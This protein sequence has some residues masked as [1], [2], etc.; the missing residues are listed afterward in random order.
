MMCVGTRLPFALYQLT[1]I[2]N[3]VLARFHLRPLLFGMWIT[4]EKEL[5]IRPE[6]AERKRMIKHKNGQ[7]IKSEPTQTHA[8]YIIHMLLRSMFNHFSLSTMDFEANR[9]C[10]NRHTHTDQKRYGEERWIRKNLVGS[11]LW[12]HPTQLCVLPLIRSMGR[13]TWLITDLKTACL[14][15]SLFRCRCAGKKIQS[16]LNALSQYKYLMEQLDK[17]DFKD[18]R[19]L[20][21]YYVHVQQDK[22]SWSPMQFVR[23]LRSFFGSEVHY[24]ADAFTFFSSTSIAN[25]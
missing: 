4:G 13:F 23:L 6:E 20:S 9:T 8:N 7:I 21:I 24:L 1:Y 11:V 3:T 10:E 18:E 25:K 17:R 16:M 15:C 2:N 14:N 5:F 22:R 12:K 19:R